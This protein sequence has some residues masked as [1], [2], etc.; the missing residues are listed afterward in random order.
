MCWQDPEFFCHDKRNR[1]ALA[2][3]IDKELVRDRLY[4][5]EVMEIKGWDAVTPSTTGYTPDLDP[6]PFDP[7]KARQLMAEAGY[8]TP[9]NPQGKDPGKMIINT[10]IAASLPL[11]PEGAQLMASMWEKELGLEV[12]VRI[13]DKSALKAAEVAGE[14]AGQAFY[15][16]NETRV[17]AS[18]ITKIIFG[19][20]D[21]PQRGQNDPDMFALI[22]ETLAIVDPEEQ[23]AAIK[24]LYVLLREEHN[25]IG[26]GF[27]NIP[28]AVGPQVV[29]WEPKPL[30][31]YPNN[32]HKIVL[33]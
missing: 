12:E 3:A 9:S 22:D 4:G 23:A 17:D 25:D 2:Y 6:F 32:L 7:E 29:S 15:R 14:L 18:G 28:W 10:V 13:G 8:R 27:L 20:P 24:K 16:E 30:S 31:Q 11:L 5:A 21:R 1:H 26:L 19:S 33:K